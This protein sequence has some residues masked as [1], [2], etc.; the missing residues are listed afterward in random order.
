MNLF[1][2]M[3]SPTSSVGRIDEDGILNGS[4]RNERSRNTISRTGKNAFEYSTHDGSRSAAASTCSRC[5][6]AAGASIA[7]A[8][9]R[10]RSKLAI[11]V[12]AR[13]RRRPSSMSLST[14]QAKPVIAVNI[15]RISAKVIE[16]PVVGIE[17]SVAVAERR[18][19]PSPSSANCSLF[20]Y[21]QNCEERFL[22]THDAADRLHPLLAGL[23]LLEQ[24]LLAGHVAAVAFGQHVLAQRLDCFA[25]DD[26]RTDRGLHRHVEHLPWNER[27]HLRCNF[28]PAMDGN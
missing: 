21:L 3:K 12:R 24:L 17:C 14:S 16:V 11:A 2:R 26:L 28:A 22:R 20:A 5:A 4:A 10:W 1:T 7:G 18:R 19:W 27:A 25:R 15:N 9:V 8:A 6:V 23:L 13:S